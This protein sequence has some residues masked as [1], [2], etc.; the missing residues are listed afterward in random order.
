M[1]L[2][3]MVNIIFFKE[4]NRM[5]S[6]NKFYLQYQEGRYTKQE[7]SSHL[8]G[9]IFKSPWYFNLNDFTEDEISSFLVWVYKHI[10]K[11]LDNYNENTSSFI[12]YFTNAIRLLVKS[13]RRQII[14]D[15][16]LQNILDNHHYIESRNDTCIVSEPPILYTTTKNKDIDLKGPL[17]K[18]HRLT[19]LVLA[20]RSLYTLNQS[21]IDK[22]PSLTG[23][24]QEE[25][26][27]W[28]E[29]I[30]EKMK[31]KKHIY[32][33]LERK[34]NINYILSQQ[35]EIELQNL[36]PDTSHYMTLNRKY[37]FYK[38]RLHQLR[39][40]RNRYKLRPTNKLIEETLNIPI[41]SMRRI[42]DNA[43]KYIN[44]IQKLIDPKKD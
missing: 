26:H 42:I 22:I 36:N 11:I 41:G 6:V 3:Y 4:F 9:E 21:V 27:Q 25:F 23:I 18:K 16:I 8:L 44:Q 15:S 43:E 13:W 40:L 29:T 14:K 32:D 20:L 10:P 39:M 12:T 7:T 1:I 33:E 37:L 19:I 2:A 38:K 30:K 5:L 31:N 28:I 17:S 34:I 35:Y 24:S